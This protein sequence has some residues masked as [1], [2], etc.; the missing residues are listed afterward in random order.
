VLALGIGANTAIFSVVNAVLLRPIPYPEP[1][2]LMRVWHTPPQKAFPGMTRFSVSAAN[3]EDWEKENHVFESMAI[4]GYRGF[5]LTGSGEP[6][7]VLGAGVSA[8]FFSTV[9]VQP[10]LGRVFTEDEN[11]AG[12]GDVVILSHSLWKSRFGGDPGIVGRNVPMNDKSYLVVG[13]MPAN[14][15]LPGWA[16]LWTP[17]AWTDQQRT[18]RGNHNYLVIARLKQGVS[19]E[20]AQS[21][22]NTISSRLEQQYPED[23]KG[24]GAVVIPLQSDMVS[25]VRPALLVLLGAVAAVLLIVRAHVA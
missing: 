6:E 2:R 3:Y 23:D 11:Q 20:Q 4:Y 15:V 13:V 24:W 5:N 16:Q 18:V 1:D 25:D 12:R 17:M 19:A 9:R 8:Q 14:M 7:R 10:L 21:E 22:M